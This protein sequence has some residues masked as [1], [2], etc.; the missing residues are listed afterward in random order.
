MIPITI[1]FNAYIPK[2]LGKPLLSYFEHDS[3]FNL[4]KM[5]N[6]YQFRQ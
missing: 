3:R 2:N 1:N 5:A 6:Y 4:N